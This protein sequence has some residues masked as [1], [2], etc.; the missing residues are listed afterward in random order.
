MGVFLTQRTLTNIAHNKH[1]FRAKCIARI[2]EEHCMSPDVHTARHQTL[3]EPGLRDFNSNKAFNYFVFLIQNF[4]NTRGYQIA[5]LSQDVPYF[6][7]LDT[8]LPASLFPSGSWFADL[9]TAVFA[10]RIKLRQTDATR[11]A[12]GVKM[13]WFLSQQWCITGNS[14]QESAPRGKKKKE[15]TE[16]WN[17]H[18]T[19]LAAFDSGDT[20]I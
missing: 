19:S 2:S 15:P 12:E 16:A 14:S 7:T 20:A 18:F 11:S 3:R 13:A 5:G 10:L 4:P 6:G 1:T 9:W 17:E 8:L